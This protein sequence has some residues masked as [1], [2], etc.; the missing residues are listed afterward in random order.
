MVQVYIAEAHAADEWPIGSR[1]WTARQ[2]GSLEERRECAAAQQER[3]GAVP[4]PVLLDGMGD[5]FLR[6]YG[7]WPLR[8]LL[9]RGLKL[10]WASAP[11][12]CVHNLHDLAAELEKC[13]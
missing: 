2:H 5:T 4:W 13:E 12:A 3:L 11:E 10:A 9:F 7:A 8:V 1:T 6:L